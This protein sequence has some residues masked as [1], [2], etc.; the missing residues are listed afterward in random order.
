MKEYEKLAKN[1]ETSEKVLE[2][3]LR[4]SCERKGWLCLK[5]TNPWLIGMPDRLILLPKG[6]CAWVELKSAG[7]KPRKIQTLRHLMLLEHQQPVYVA[8]SRE[9]IDAIIEELSDGI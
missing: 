8:S 4:Q 6:R 7:E 1:S 3:Y 9:N 5:Y 2:L